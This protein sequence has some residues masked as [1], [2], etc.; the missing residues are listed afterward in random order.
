MSR[1]PYPAKQIRSSDGHIR[2]DCRYPYLESTSSSLSGPGGSRCTRWHPLFELQ[3]VKAGHSLRGPL[4]EFRVERRT[5]LFGVASTAW[6]LRLRDPAISSGNQCE[7]ASRLTSCG[8]RYI[9]NEDG[10]AS[11]DHA[12]DYSLTSGL[13]S[14]RFSLGPAT[15][16]LRKQI[17]FR[18]TRSSPCHCTEFKVEVPAGS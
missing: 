1:Q 10:R 3:V 11:L 8:Y 17:R 7:D 5:L 12:F 4:T 14:P 9:V 15:T 16:P 18:I 2:W 6:F 13:S